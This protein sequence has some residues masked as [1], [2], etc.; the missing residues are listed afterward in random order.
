MVGLCARL[1]KC[2]E[3]ILCLGGA[4]PK[5]RGW[6]KKR[7]NQDSAFSENFKTRHVYEMPLA[8]SGQPFSGV[9]R[10]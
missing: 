3:Q 4:V 8:Y 5:G 2:T 6:G 9:D 1:H 7:K 10:W